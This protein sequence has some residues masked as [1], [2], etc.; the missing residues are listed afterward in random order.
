LEEEHEDP[1]REREG[2]SG[3]DHGAVLVKKSDYER[4]WD[5]EEMELEMGY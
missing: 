2:S 4:E 3:S 5:G 1:Y